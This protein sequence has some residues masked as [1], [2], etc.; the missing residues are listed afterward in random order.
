MALASPHR[1]IG[2]P[3]AGGTTCSTR[4][5]TAAAWMARGR[6]AMPSSL[7]GEPSGG[8]NAGGEISANANANAAPPQGSG[9]MAGAPVSAPQPWAFFRATRAHVWVCAR[10]APRPVGACAP[11]HSCARACMYREVLTR[12]SAPSQYFAPRCRRSALPLRT[13]CEL[14]RSVG[15]LDEARSRTAEWPHLELGDDGAVV[16]KDGAPKPR[17]S[18]AAAVCAVTAQ[19]V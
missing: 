8:G 1:R 14:N 10:N 4:A 6:R 18:N 2:G 13:V 3:A 12:R 7:H 5:A 19:R 9:S 17:P 11:G 16:A 15:L